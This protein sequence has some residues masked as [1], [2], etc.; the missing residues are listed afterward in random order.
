MSVSRELEKELGLLLEEAADPYN[1][2]LGRAPEEGQGEDRR[3]QGAPR[4]QPR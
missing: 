1:R 3:R 2:V 4:S